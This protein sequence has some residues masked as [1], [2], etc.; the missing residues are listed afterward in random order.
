MSG[1]AAWVGVALLG[2]AAA[3]ARVAA[4]RAVDARTRSAL[5]IGTAVVNLAG[6]LALGVL[7]GLGATGDTL[8]LAG[9]AVLGS[10]TTF[11]TWVLEARLLGRGRPALALAHL[12]VLTVAGVAAAALGRAIAGG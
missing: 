2:G 3:V 6:A 8:L 11:S 7:V 4:S 9:T 5:P 12:L 10:F 1:A